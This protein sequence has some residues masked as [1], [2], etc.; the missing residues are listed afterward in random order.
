[1]VQEVITG[2]SWLSPNLQTSAF[3][4]EQWAKSDAVS[5]R[6]SDSSFNPI[7]AEDWQWCSSYACFHAD[8][9]RW[10][11]IPMIHL[12]RETGVPG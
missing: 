10:L 6:A 12:C 8:E 2:E 5:T 3:L 1:M 7:F 4:A 11:A 9:R